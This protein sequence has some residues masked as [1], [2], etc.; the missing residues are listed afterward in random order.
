MNDAHQQCR[1]SPLPLGDVV[2][3]RCYLLCCDIIQCMF[4]VGVANMLVLIDIDVVLFLT[5]FPGL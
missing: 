5:A 1:P 4:D 2:A 3:G